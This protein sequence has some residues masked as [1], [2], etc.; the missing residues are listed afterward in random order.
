[1]ESL[2]L[3]LPRMGVASL[4]KKSSKKIRLKRVTERK[5]VPAL[6][7]DYRSVH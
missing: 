2:N 3:I 6:E 1:M 4:R 7:A 5:I